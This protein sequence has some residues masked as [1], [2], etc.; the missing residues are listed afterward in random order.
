[1]DSLRAKI[2]LVY[3]ALASLAVCLSLLALV[4]LR[5]MTAK[6]QASGL[7]AE[8]FDAALELRRFEK[9]FFLYG[10]PEDLGENRRYAEEALALLQRDLGVFVDLMGEP[11]VVTLKE[12]LRRYADL[13]AQMERHPRDEGLASRVRALGKAIVTAGEELARRERQGLSEDLAAHQRSL[14]ISFAT[15]I[16]L[17]ALAGFLLAHWVTRPLKQMET[18]M[19]ALVRGSLARLDP[20]VRDRELVSLCG[21][22]NL[23]LDELERRQRTLVRSEKLASL[24]TLLAGVAHE[25]NNPL[26][27]ISSSAQILASEPDA[28][29]EFRRELLADIDQESQRAARIVRS[30]LDYTRES[31]TGTRPVALAELVDET[32]GFLRNRRGPGVS[33]RIDIAPDLKVPANRARLQQ[34][35]VNLIGNAL[36]AM[37]EHGELSI[38]AQRGQARRTGLGGGDTF[39]PGT[40]VVDI[41]I[42]DTGPGIPPAVLPRIF[43]PFFTTKAVGKGSG[44]GLFIVYQIV[45]EHGGWIGA[46]NRDEGGARF[47]IR[48]PDQPTASGKRARR[49]SHD[50]AHPGR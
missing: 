18:R 10:Q 11:A 4:E 45:E 38:G 2:I 47:H 17:L 32:L 36:E 27:N 12:E 42:S 48:L 33:V 39:A 14:L 50:H 31:G 22:F 3:L 43:D 30:L 35:L 15:V 44:L 26:S 25:L 21:A 46:R 16:I 19:E 7:V 20:E 5:L 41:L 34:A 40:P 29:P 24:G 37:G 9:N 6:V 8:F 28:E 23:V 1:M 49:P 13:M